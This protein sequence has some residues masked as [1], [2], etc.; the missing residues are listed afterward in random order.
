MLPSSKAHRAALSARVTFLL[1]PSSHGETLTWT[2]KAQIWRHGDAL[3]RGAVDRAVVERD[4]LKRGERRKSRAESYHPTSAL[5]LMAGSVIPRNRASTLT[6]TR[7]WTG[8]LS[9]AGKTGRGSL[10]SGRQKLYAGIVNRPKGGGQGHSRS[11]TSRP[12]DFEPILTPIVVRLLR[13]LSSTLPRVGTRHRPTIIAT[14]D[15][16]YAPPSRTKPGAQAS[17]TPGW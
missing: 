16:Y 1:T 2:R 3:G 12:N 11:M 15:Y 13:S 10:C 6:V 5:R 7:R 8:E 9:E 4:H 14:S 17:S